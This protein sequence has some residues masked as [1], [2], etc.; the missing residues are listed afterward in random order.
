MKN[1][2]LLLVTALTLAGCAT[3]RPPVSEL[4][5]GV[6]KALFVQHGDKPLSYS[7]GVID[8]ASFWGAYGDG[9][10]AQTGGWLWSGLAGSGRQDAAEKQLTNAELVELLYADHN[11]IPAV[12]DAVLPELSRLWKQRYAARNRITVAQDAILIDPN[13]RELIGLETDAD[14]VLLLNVRNVNLTERFSLGAAFASGFTMGSNEKSLTTEVLVMMHAFKPDQQGAYK[15]VWSQPCGT[16]YTSMDTSY[17][18][19]EL[20]A[21]KSRITEILDE[22][23]LKSIESCSKVLNQLAAK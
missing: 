4:S 8:T 12:S 2:I 16:N 10:A 9:V 6:K 3:S 18:M 20:L 21:S 13:S 1:L 11:L 19:Q 15:E 5:Q 14:L 23:T 22:A 7:T 17:Y